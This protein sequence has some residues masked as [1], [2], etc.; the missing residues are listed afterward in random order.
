[1]E[2]F[3]FF[4][5]PFSSVKADNIGKNNVLN[6][7]MLRYEWLIKLDFFLSRWKEE[8]EK[9]GGGGGYIR[10]NMDMQSKSE[11]PVGKPDPMH[12]LYK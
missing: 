9:W 1:M 3:S 5:C 2:F 10:E 12:S 8:E 4:Q 7:F 11:E 6:L